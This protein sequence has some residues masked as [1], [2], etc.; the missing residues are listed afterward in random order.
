[1]TTLQ[2]KRAAD[3]TDADWSLWLDI[4]QNSSAYAS[5]YFRP[6]FTRAVA[7][8]RD[9]VE[10]A[11]LVQSG[12][13]VGFFPFQR[14]SLGL[15]KPVG[16]KLSD[17]HGPLV[18]PETPLD[19]RALL[20]ACKLSSWDFDHFISATAGFEPFVTLRDK[21]PQLDLS[22]GFEAYVRG[23]REA[24]S[25]T[26]H[27]QGQKTRKLAREVGPL[28]FAY[29][30][31]D[32]G[33]FELLKTWK[34]EQLVRTGLPDLFAFPWTLAL[35]A[36]LREHQGD[37]FS[38]PLTVLRAGDEV[39]AVCLSLRSRDVLHA[40]FTAFNPKFSQCSP[41]LT[42]FVRLAEEAKQLGIRKID[43]GRGRERYKWSLASGSVD[44]GEGSVSTRSL[45]TLLRASWRRTRDWVAGSPLAGRI[46]M[47]GKLLKPI[48]EWLSYH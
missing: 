6:E 21:S 45:A 26:V 27:R 39:A 14:G 44:V 1:M 37:E 13:T 7:A 46:T 29:S 4:Q 15:G 41:G 47:P 5:P 22:E 33:A 19:P 10:I 12:Q 40:W 2:L 30:A 48:R 31:D 25:D 24:G 34:S 32:D 18:R 16:G 28:D 35:L 23:R 36:K 3:L 11:A 20:A 8:V 42:L 9:D 43:L 17:Y 38:A